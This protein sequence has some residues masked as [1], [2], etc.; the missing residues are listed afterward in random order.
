[1]LQEFYVCVTRKIAK[2]LP[3]AHA[4]NVVLTYA[5]WCVDVSAAEIAAA[6]RIE[7]ASKISFWDALICAAAV[8]AGAGT[9]L[10]EDLN[11]GQTIAGIRIKNPF[12][13]R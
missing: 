13:A 11:A 2:P 1:V 4:R 3:K 5:T 6:F 10:S 7:D 8:K 12:K 9:I